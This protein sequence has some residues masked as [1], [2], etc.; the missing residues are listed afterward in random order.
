MEFISLDG[1]RADG[2]RCLELRRIKCE[3]GSLANA[4]GSASVEMGLSKALA[5]VSGPKEVTDRSVQKGNSNIVVRCEF[6]MS[7]FS[8]GARRARSRLDRRNMEMGQLIET[9]VQQS[10]LPEAF[11]RTQ[12]DISVTVL[13]ADGGA[14]PCAMNAVMLAV[15]DAGIPLKDLA[16][17]CSAGLLEQQHVLDM[18]H[19]EESTGCPRIFAAL[20]PNLD[21]LVMVQMFNRLDS[22]AFE[23]LLESVQAGC[24]KV[25]GEMQR[26]LNERV[27]QLAAGKGG[28]RM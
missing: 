24:I 2:R 16:A 1:L 22:D 7:P 23:S 3:L 21:T 9:T 14:E 15:A 5:T 13:E 17:A 18:N 27:R 19:F 6:M 8:T 28:Y 10:I 12:L 11:A 26:A 4:D 25:Y 20:Q